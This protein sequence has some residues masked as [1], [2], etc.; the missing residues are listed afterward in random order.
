MCHAVS[1]SPDYDD[2]GAHTKRQTIVVAPKTKAGIRSIHVPPV[3]TDAL[4]DWKQYIDEKKPDH[5]EYIFCSTKTG[6]LR[7]YNAFRT[8]FRKFLIRNGLDN[9]GIS[10]H[11]FRHTAA[12]ILL[13]NNISPR[14]VQRILGHADIQTTLG[15]YSHVM[16]EVYSDVASALGN[17]Y[18]ETISGTYTPGTHSKSTVNIQ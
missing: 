15:T 6:Q 11:N 14:V 13:E 4:R 12:T 8:S 18:N 16:Q 17:I 3:V 10:L 1:I 9:C 7:T 5:S 2:S